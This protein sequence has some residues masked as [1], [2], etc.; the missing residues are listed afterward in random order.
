M[1]GK[2]VFP[3]GNA[4]SLDNI[5]GQPIAE[6]VHAKSG[7]VHKLEGP[8]NAKNIVFKAT[9]DYNDGD[10]WI[11]NN[12]PVA[13]TYNGGEELLPTAVLVGDVVPAIIM[14]DQV[15]LMVQKPTPQPNILDGWYFVDP[16][17]QRGQK[18]YTGATYTVDRW[19]MSIN[20]GKLNVNDGYVTL[21]NTSATGA[22]YFTQPFEVRFKERDILTLAVML[23]GNGQ[24]QL[25]LG[26]SETG[27]NIGGGLSFTPTNDWKVYIKTVKIGNKIP[28]YFTLACVG[29]NAHFDIK[30]AKTEYQKRFTGWPA[31]DYGAELAKCQRYQYYKSGLWKFLGIGICPGFVNGKYELTTFVSLPVTMRTNPVAD[32]KNLYVTGGVSD[33]KAHKVTG[34]R[35][36]QDYIGGVELALQT[37]D[38][39]E[40]GVPYYLAIKDTNGYFYLNA[41]L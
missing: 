17:N 41:N 13:V 27:A 4:Q 30:C 23:R 8:V 21:T 18:E 15:R 28:K 16:V 37:D 29:E 40:A 7:T 34:I 5:A 10:T 33:Y 32:F 20:R 6:Y 2:A 9:G 25:F 14:G 22:Q 26:D 31:W 3:G 36:V 19:Q 24:G 35:V 11:L 1:N 38:T 12:T 39:L